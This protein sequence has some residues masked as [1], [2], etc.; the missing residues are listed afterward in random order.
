[1]RKTI[2]LLLLLTCT[3]KSQNLEENSKFKNTIS[4]EFYQPFQNNIREFYNDDWILGYEPSEKSYYSR[5]AFSNAFGISYER[6]LKNFILRTRFGVSVRKIEESNG[7]EN[8]SQEQ[9]F[10][11][12]LSKE[13]S[14][15]QI[16]INSLIGVIKRVNLVNNFDLD[17][18]IDFAFVHYQ[19][20]EGKLQYNI[21]EKTISDDRFLREQIINV[22]DRIGSIQSIGFGPILKPLYNFSDRLVVSAEFQVYFMNTFT[23]DKTIRLETSQTTFEDGSS[24]NIEISQEINYNINQWNWTKISPLIRI[25][26]LF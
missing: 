26:Y 1:M 15:K 8:I 4:L 10:T 13:Y 19:K 24:E 7:Y 20:A 16:H 22:N 18:G 12:I 6:V 2:F 14:Y 23:K 17:L 21:N 5:N 25:G 9:N 11:S 3:V